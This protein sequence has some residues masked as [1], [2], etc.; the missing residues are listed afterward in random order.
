VPGQEPVQTTHRSSSAGGIA[1]TRRHH[2][3]WTPLSRRRD[4]LEFQ[5]NGW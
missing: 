1:V 4:A 2:D 5:P 3:I